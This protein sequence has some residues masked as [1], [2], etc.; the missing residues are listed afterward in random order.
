MRKL[1]GYRKNGGMAMKYTMVLW[2]LIVPL[3]SAA[4]DK[5]GNFRSKDFGAEKCVNV[6]HMRS[7]DAGAFLAS[8][9]WL[10]G[11]L[12]GYNVI[13]QGNYDAAGD[14][15]L[16]TLDSLIMSYCRQNPEETLSSGAIWLVN[17]LKPIAL[18]AKP[19][20]VTPKVGGK[21]VTVSKQTVRFVQ[22][23][24]KDRGYYRG[25]ADGSFGLETKKALEKFQNE[26]GFEASGLPDQR[27][28]VG[29]LQQP[30]SPKK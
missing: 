4:A 22:H 1:S 21:S 5:D 3:I 16:E 19:E 12:T 6:L 26:S 28:I 30:G 9:S 10:N 8:R 29:L 14:L 27:T 25:V 11:F 23:R 20:F 18:E 17:V 2:I 24:L 7:Q 13:A 15:A